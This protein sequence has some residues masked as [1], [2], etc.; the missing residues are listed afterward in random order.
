MDNT[1]PKF[2][3]YDNGCNYC[4]KGM[5]RFNISQRYP[6]FEEYFDDVIS[7]K[8]KYQCILGISGGVDS[9]Y[10]ALKLKEFNIRTLLLHVDCGW[11]TEIATQNI[12]MILNKTNFDY[13][14]IVP[15]WSLM[16]NLQLAYLNSGVYNQDVPQDHAFVAGMYH[17]ANKYNIKNMVSGHSSATENVPNLWQH[18]AMDF[19]NIKS[20]TKSFTKDVDFSTY[21]YMNF[22]NYYFVY[23]FLKRIKFLTPLDTMEYSKKNALHFLKF[24][25]YKEYSGKHGESSFTKY[26]QDVFLP[27]KYGIYKIKTH[28]SSLIVN[29]ELTRDEAISDLKNHIAKIAVEEHKIEKFFCDKL[30]IS[31]AEYIKLFNN[32]TN[33][34]SDYNNWDSFKKI[35]A[36]V[37]KFV[38]IKSHRE[39]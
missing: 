18:D 22:I 37:K 13:E 27:K 5:E 11:D 35:I 23:P 3:K 31:P 20:I 32:A 9:S 14:T 38:K 15:D 19:I 16:K 29:G 36:Y 25:G 39:S 10:L 33:M 17:M 4:R 12:S 34:Y 2:I 6:P 24:N 30:D 28:L 1:F 21:P 8:E 26:F 7:S